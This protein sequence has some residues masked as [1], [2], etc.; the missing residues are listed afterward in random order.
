MLTSGSMEG[1]KFGVSSGLKCVTLNM[2][3]KA[4]TM[5]ISSIGAVLDFLRPDLEKAVL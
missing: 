2:S 5:A 4:S 1:V 3:F